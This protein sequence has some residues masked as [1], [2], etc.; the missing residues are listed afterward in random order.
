M[1]HTNRLRFKLET[2]IGRLVVTYLKGLI[3]HDI[4]KS[5]IGL[6]F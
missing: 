2:L 4:C 6:D 5:I 1:L 3:F